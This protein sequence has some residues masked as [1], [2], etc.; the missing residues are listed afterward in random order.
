MSDRHLRALVGASACGR[1]SV[2]PR[3]H[4]ILSACKLAG[5]RTNFNCPF[6]RPLAAGRRPASAI[7]RRL[8]GPLRNP[9][10]WVRARGGPSIPLNWLTFASRAH[11]LV[12]LLPVH[13]PSPTAGSFVKRSARFRAQVC[14]RTGASWTKVGGALELRKGAVAL[15]DAE[16][17][18][19]RQ[20]SPSHSRSRSLS[21]SRWLAQCG[22]KLAGW[23]AGWT[24]GRP[25]RPLVPFERL[26]SRSAWPTRHCCA[27]RQRQTPV[28]RAR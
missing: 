26:L 28:A 16:T 25:G 20:P 9:M 6:R 10:H 18:L 23:L 1:A 14:R 24:A 13:A 22:R 11:R 8:S 4:L 27:R 17:T 7:E 5:A 3:V 19:S 21:L 15:R 12:R 2:R